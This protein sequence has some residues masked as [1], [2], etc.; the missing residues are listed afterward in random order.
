VER[1]AVLQGLASTYLA[2]EM[3][4]RAIGVSKEMYELALATFGT[5]N[6]RI[7]P[8]GNTHGLVLTAAGRYREAIAIFDPLLKM[9]GLNAAFRQILALNRLETGSLL[10]VIDSDTQ[11]LAE[12]IW[13]QR[14]QLGR[15]NLTT[16]LLAQMRL[17]HL[18]NNSALA[19]QRLLA[20]PE[21][22]W[23]EAL[24][25][26]MELSIWDQLLH[27]E[28]PIT[29]ERVKWRAQLEAD[30]TTNQNLLNAIRFG[31]GRTKSTP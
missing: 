23:S 19:A 16:V 14:D 7:M 9:P 3:A 8:Y 17:L 30:P 1:L 24:R 6:S 15:G 13:A 2:K 28:T 11:A 26:R 22:E 10:S 21:S 31:F 29:P 27:P 25:A 4:Q 20:V 12:Q 18:S 5:E